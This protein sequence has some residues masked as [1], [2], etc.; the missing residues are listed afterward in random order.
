MQET[1]TT[2]IGID[3][4]TDNAKVGLA[5][6]FWENDQ[7]R[8]LCT[9]RGKGKGV[10]DLAKQI[11]KWIPD[12]SRTLLALDAPLG[13]PEPLGPTLKDHKAGQAISIEANQLFRRDTD[14]FM[15]ETIGQRPLDVGADRI[16]RTA[17]TALALLGE[18]RELTEQCIPLAW[19]PVLDEDT[20]AIEVYPA[21]TLKLFGIRSSRYKQKGQMKERKEILHA[22]AKHLVLPS[23]TEQMIQNA[24]ILDAVICILAAADF[25]WGKAMVPSNQ[26]LAEKEGWIWVQAPDGSY[27]HSEKIG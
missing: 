22:L 27:N 7:V 25:L 15:I 10:A 21:A 18:L 26:E 3:C 4:A 8:V 6:G 11:A 5:R 17:R 14:R 19:D 12:N 1:E 16:A 24:D 23:D 13:W 9:K 20:S 2:I